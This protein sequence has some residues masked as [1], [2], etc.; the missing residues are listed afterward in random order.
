MNNPE[1]TD[2][3]DEDVSTNSNLKILTTVLSVSQQLIGIKEKLNVL[4]DSMAKRQS[5]L[6]RAAQFWHGMVL[7]K[8]IILGTV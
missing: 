3:S 7:W 6:S 2:S 5:L 1:H 4:V 8:K